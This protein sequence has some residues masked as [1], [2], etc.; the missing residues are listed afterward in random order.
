LVYHVVA[1]GKRTDLFEK[2]QME[3]NVGKANKRI[4]KLI[5]DGGIRWNSTYAMIERALELREALDAYAFKL[6]SSTDPYDKETF[7]DDLGS[8][9]NDPGPP[10]TSLPSYEIPRRQYYPQRSC[11]EAVTWCFVGNTTDISVLVNTL[12]ESGKRSQSRQILGS[13]KHTKLD[14]FGMGC[15]GEMVPKD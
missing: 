1:S 10:Q 12:G 2:L 4:W 11:K 13:Q 7:T 15:Y 9:R 3:A 6:R 5:L 14:H 8:F